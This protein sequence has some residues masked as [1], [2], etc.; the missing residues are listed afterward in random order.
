M[1]TMF[2][3]DEMSMTDDVRRPPA[4][5]QPTALGDL[6]DVVAERA[7]DGAVL[8]LAGAWA[9]YVAPYADRGGEDAPTDATA[10][11]WSARI[12]FGDTWIRWT[13]GTGKARRTLWTCEL[14]AIE[15]G[16]RD[17]PLIRED[18]AE[19]AHLLANWAVLTGTPWVGTPGMTGNALLKAQFPAVGKTAPKWK[20]AV[21]DWGLGDI[22][23]AYGPAQWSRAA[24]ATGRYRHAYDLNKAYL[25]ALTNVELAWDDLAPSG[26]RE[27]DKR[28][29][30]LWRVELSPWTGHATLPDPAGYAPLLDDGT[31]WVTTPTLALLDQLTE[32]GEYGGFAV[33]E[34]RTA[35]AR[36]ITRGWAKPLTDLITHGSPELAA[37][38]GRV[39]KS[40][41]GMWRRPS[42]LIHRPDWHYSVI[43]LHRANL[44][45]K[46][47]TAKAAGYLPAAL[48]ATDAVVYASDHEDWAA[49]APHTFTLD[50]TGRKLGAWK[51]G[52]DTA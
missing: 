46:L 40:T 30:G 50:P 21:S 4:S 45:R 7:A 24:P 44:W 37:A 38:A 28:L 15:P 20:A 36:R 13:R 2:L 49:A 51:P 1:K 34:A 3:S 39:Y 42:S 52:K 41:Y 43:A 12:A 19:S 10:G 11:A 35:P 17:T 26:P 8:H 5:F 18:P 25:G 48:D 27:F 32:D 47:W 16:G 31:R 9:K 6:L 23:R 22:E 33:R 29:G 14:D